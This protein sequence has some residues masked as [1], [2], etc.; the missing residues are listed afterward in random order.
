LFVTPS[1]GPDEKETPATPDAP[2]TETVVEESILEKRTAFWQ[3]WVDKCFPNDDWNTTTFITNGKNYD[4]FKTDNPEV[5]QAMADMYTDPAT[6]TKYLP[7]V[8][9]SGSTYPMEVTAYIGQKLYKIVPQ[10]RDIAGPSP[11]YVTETQL[12]SIKLHP[13]ELEQKLG[14]PLSSV[15]GEYWIYTITSVADD[16]LFFQSSIASTDQYANATPEVVYSTPG[17]AVQSLLINNGDPMKWKKS[18][19]PEEKYIPDTLPKVE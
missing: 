16:N 18:T 3:E 1:C 4:Q 9:R 13:E 19:T 12:E 5:W 14:L 2:A 10:G 17:G 6:A 8:V 11:Y 7:E 15:S